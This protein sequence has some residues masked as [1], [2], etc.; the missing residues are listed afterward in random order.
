MMASP[1]QLPTLP[2]PTGDEPGDDLAPDPFEGLVD[3]D[4]IMTEF[5]TPHGTITYYSSRNQGRGEFVGTCTCAAH[6]KRCR[7]SRMA[8]A[9]D[10]KPEKGRPLCFIYSWLKH[11]HDGYADAKA[12]NKEC[13][14]SWE[15]R[16][17][18]RMEL[19]SMDGSWEICRKE[20]R[21]GEPHEPVRIP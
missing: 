13:R 15:D 1:L 6:G 10:A 21:P 7:M 8:S 12:H 14:P 20:H 4:E 19:Y 16:Q 11:A 9:V 3:V 5:L 2:V 17:N 18:A